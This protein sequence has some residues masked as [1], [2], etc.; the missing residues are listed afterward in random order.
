[1]AVSSAHRSKARHC[2]QEPRQSSGI[3]INASENTNRQ[4]AIA[5]AGAWDSR[6]SGPETE[7]PRTESS[8]TADTNEGRTVMRCAQSS[9]ECVIASV[10]R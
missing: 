9:D 7:T 6:T 1:M 3:A 4:T 8:S 2:R 5:I 10:R